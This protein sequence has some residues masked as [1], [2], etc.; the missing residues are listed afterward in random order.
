MALIRPKLNFADG[1]LDVSAPGKSVLRIPLSRPSVE[2]ESDEVTLWGADMYGVDQGK[3][4]NE[5]FSDFLGAVVRLVRFP[6]NHAREVDQKYTVLSASQ[7]C[8]YADGFPYLVANEGSAKVVREETEADCGSDPVTVRR[9]RPNVVVSGFNAWEELLF[10]RAHVGTAVTLHLTKPCTRCKLTTVVPEKG[11]FGG[12]QPLKFIRNA[13]K[14][15]FGMNAIHTPRS[16]GKIV[17]VGDVFSVD[18]F[19]EAEMEVK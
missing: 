9:F 5:W 14:A 6:V 8:S 7:V 19:R 18:K 11:V 15:I 1:T 3:E 4:A 2:G 10:E 12:E 13:R 16:L 17:K